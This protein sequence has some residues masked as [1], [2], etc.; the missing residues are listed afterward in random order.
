MERILVL[1]NIRSIHNVGACFRSADGAGFSHII[2]CGYTPDPSDTRIGKVALGA[3]R[4]IAWERAAS[5]LAAVRRL[6]AQ[7]VTVLALEHTESAVCLY[8]FSLPNGD[9]ALVV[10]HEVDGIS[11]DVLA[12]ADATVMLPMRGMKESLNVSVAAGIAMYECV[13]Q[14][15]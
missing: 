10:G 7:G 15:T 14:S 2:C 5:A 12:A 11:A 13:R 4:A 3:E 1:E 6:Q 9:L 8:D